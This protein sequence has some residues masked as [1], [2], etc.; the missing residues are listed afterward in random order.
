M[1]GISKNI[2]FLLLLLAMF[3]LFRPYVTEAA[4]KFSAGSTIAHVNI[5]GLTVQEAKIKIQEEIAKWINSGNLIAESKAGQREIPK[6]IFT[7]HIDETLTL[8]EEKTKRHWKNF[9]MKEKNVH[10]PLQVEVGDLP[11]DL[12]PFVDE[13]RLKDDLEQIASE[14]GNETVTLTYVET[15]SEQI[16]PIAEITFSIPD[17]SSTVTKYIAEQFVDFEI[18]ANSLYSLLEHV[19]LLD[20]MENSEEEM[21]FIA[22]ALYTLILHTNMEV[23]ERHSQGEI[24]SYSEAGLEAAVNRKENRD[25]VIFNP[26]EYPYVLDAKIAENK[27][28][29]T[30]SSIPA[31]TSYEFERVNTKEIKP[32]TIYRYDPKLS[33]GETKVIQ[34]GKNGLQVEIYRN[35]NGD[36]DNKELI[37][38]DYYPPIPEIVALSA[39]QGQIEDAE[40]MEPT[41][42]LPQMDVTSLIDEEEVMGNLPNLENILGQEHEDGE[43]TEDLEKGMAALFY[44]CLLQAGTGE[45]SETDSEESLGLCDLFLLSLLFGLFSEDTAN[46]V[47][48]PEEMENLIELPDGS[49]ELTEGLNT[50]A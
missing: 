46:L 39:R 17:I 18:P 11:E 42:S 23:I 45:N 2:L 24:P 6:A 36:K 5:E 50:D 32:R 7:F 49:D 14:L 19:T 16:E 15:I 28:T 9:F 1:K 35:A 34:N 33:P 44:A 8:L 4:G 48:P 43:N 3:S 20:G 47:N 29:M 37:S 26:N 22:S 10:L 31:E 13:E 41:G 30:I 21:S 38:R 40:E 27:L 12:P 25:F